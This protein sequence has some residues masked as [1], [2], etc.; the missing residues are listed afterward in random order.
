MILALEGA[1]PEIGQGCFVAENAVVVGDVRVG[2]NSSIW[3]GSI[4]RGD[5]ASISIGC[6]TNIQDM[7]MLHVDTSKD[8]CI[9]S[10]V[11]VGH[12]A[13]VHACTVRDR[14]LV[15][16]GAVIMNGAEIGE[17]SIV[18][19]GSIVTEGVLIPPRSLVLG[20]PGKVRRGLT[21][22]EVLSIA[23]SARVYVR[24]ARKYIA[25]NLSSLG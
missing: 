2:C 13:I 1:L 9:G 16:M 5:M 20:T 24:M 22:D 25:S 18:G 14:V 12:G 6:R 10:D 11:T 19:A 15:G 21:S 4:V 8:L 7:A 3:Y 17:D 23:E